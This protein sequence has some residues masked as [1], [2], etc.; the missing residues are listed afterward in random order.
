MGDEDLLLGILRA[1]EGVTREA[2]AFVGVTPEAAR[3]TS[4]EPTADALSS[5]G[6]SLEKV[7]RGAGGSFEMLVP[8]NRRLPFSPRRRRRWNRRSGRR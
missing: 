8:G 7:R 5:V 4:E 3:G 2:L 6:I 1:G